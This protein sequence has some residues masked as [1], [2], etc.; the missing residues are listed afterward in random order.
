MV[1]KK[2]MFSITVKFYHDDIE[3]EIE[4]SKSVMRDEVQRLL[5]FFK[6]LRWYST[7]KEQD[8]AVSVSTTINVTTDK[9]FNDIDQI[10]KMLLK[11]GFCSDPC[12]VEFLGKMYEISLESGVVSIVDNY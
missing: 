4:P 8:D 9:P 11:N 5:K 3:E 10:A 6:D 1:Q 2:S 12:N 7:H